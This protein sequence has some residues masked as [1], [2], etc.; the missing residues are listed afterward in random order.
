MDIQTFEKEVLKIERLLYH[1]SWSMLSNQEDCA[2]AVQ[3]ALTR[4]WE[5]RHSLQNTKAFRNWLVQILR[6]VCTDVLRKRKNQRFTRIE[7]DALAAI[8]SEDDH[9]ST[10]EML[11][12]LSPEHRLVVVLHYLEGYKIR[13]IAQ[14]LATPAGT[15]KSRLMKARIYLRIAIPTGADIHGGINNEKK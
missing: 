10:L 8:S 1:V 12:G 3:E 9:Y 15:I 14:M 4:A 2:D 7:E 13:D 5:K 6:N 11:Q